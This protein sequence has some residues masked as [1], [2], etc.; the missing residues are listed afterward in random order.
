MGDTLANLL[1]AIPGRKRAVLEEGD[2]LAMP[3][4]NLVYLMFYMGA[5]RSLHSRTTIKFNLMVGM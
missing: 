3:R 5:D 2:A 1:R 4:G